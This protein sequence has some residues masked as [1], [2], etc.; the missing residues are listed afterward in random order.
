MC[1]C[2]SSLWCFLH[3]NSIQSRQ[4]KLAGICSKVYLEQEEKETEKK[5]VF[6]IWL[7]MDISQ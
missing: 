2:F 3:D 7:Y 1:L 6:K 5:K 4:I